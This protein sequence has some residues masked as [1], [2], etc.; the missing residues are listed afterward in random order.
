MQ[1]GVLVDYNTVMNSFWSGFGKQAGHQS[2]NPLDQAIA[3][4]R[5]HLDD[6]STATP[7][8]QTKMMRLMEKAK[9]SPDSIPGGLAEGKEG[10]PPAQ[11]EMG[12]RVE[13]EHTPNPALAEEI[14]KDHLVEHR[15]YYTRLKKA[16]L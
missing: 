11:L 9:K 14:A 16:R 8:S 10:F 3:L 4:H 7:A 2:K 12:K 1:K 5:E 6:S 13:K 15:D